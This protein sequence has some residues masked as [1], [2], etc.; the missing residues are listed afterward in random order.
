M[1]ACRGIFAVAGAIEPE[2]LT[3]FI[4]DAEIVSNGDRLRIPMK[5]AIDSETKP[6]TCSDFIPA[7]IPI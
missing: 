1:G 7:S 6:A 5:P 4:F 2:P 3:S